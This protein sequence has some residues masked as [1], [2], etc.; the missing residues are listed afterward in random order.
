LLPS[1]ITTR[2]ELNAWEQLNV[3]QGEAWAFGKRQTFE[4]LL[5]VDFSLEL[6]KR[7]FG[8]TWRWAGRVRTKEVRPVGVAPEVVRISLTDLCRDVL[9]QA[10]AG[11]L[12][13]KEM[14]ARFHH[15]LVFIHPFPNGNGRFARTMADLFLALNGAPRFEWGADLVRDSDPRREYIAA[16]RAADARDFRP[17]LKLLKADQ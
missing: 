4:Q 15:R 5:T 6:H 14:A 9:A 11:D 8:D 17:L 1:H 3:T 10:S 7:M 16:L 13:I 2:E 12:S